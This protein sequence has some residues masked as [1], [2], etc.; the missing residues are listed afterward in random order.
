MGLYK[1]RSERPLHPLLSSPFFSDRAFVV[2][3]VMH[4]ADCKGVKACVLG[5]MVSLLLAGDRLGTNKDVRLQLI[6]T[7]L[8][9][10]YDQHPGTHRLP[11]LRLANV[12]SDG[13]AKLH[14]PAIKAANT[15]AAVP[16]FRGLCHR[17]F[18]RGTLRSS[19]PYT[20]FYEVLHNEP[21]FFR[22]WDQSPARGK[23]PAGYRVPKASRACSGRRQT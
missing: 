7:M 22:R 17:W 20:I 16:A 4:V 21:R 9:E 1:V 23:H 6:N 3:D 14:G 2:L 13:W 5:S 12:F 10:N 18:D 15:R 19:M 8:A 11:P